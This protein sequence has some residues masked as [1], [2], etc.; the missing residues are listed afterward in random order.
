MRKKALCFAA[1]LA[2]A[3]CTFE[4]SRSEEGKADDKRMYDQAVTAAAQLREPERYYYKDVIMQGGLGLT[5]RTTLPAA[6]MLDWSMEYFIGESGNLPDSLLEHKVWAHS[7][8]DDNGI[9]LFPDGE[10]RYR[11]VYNNGGNAST[12]SNALGTTGRQRYEEFVHAGGCYVGSCAGAFFATRYCVKTE[13]RKDFYPKYIGIWPGCIE[14][15]HLSSSYH[16]IIIDNGS[17]LLRYYSYGG[18]NYVAEVRHNGGCFCRTDLDWPQNGEVL[19]RYD[20]SM[21]SVNAFDGTPVIWSVKE[22][23]EWGRVISCG[24]HPESV[25]SGER[26]DLMAAMLCYAADGCGIA[27]VKAVLKNGDKYVCDRCTADN[28][29]QHTKIGDGQC[30]YYTV[31]IPASAKNV[32]VKLS[33]E[34]DYNIHLGAKRGCLPTEENAEYMVKD[35][36]SEKEFTIESTEECILYIGVHN[37]SRPLASSI[38]VDKNGTCIYESGKELL[39]GIAYTLSISWN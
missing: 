38:K 32:K 3:A 15:T 8:E 23:E 4:P 30:H 12:F 2:V 35:G 5:S 20:V 24:S 6:K 18:D 21:C 16:G 1:V 33:Y 22:Q 26:R 7:E 36:G 39:N 19:A 10:P 31:G 13:G 29:P 28:D 17:P 14:N 9:L 25:E 34:G 37:L 11:V 27:K